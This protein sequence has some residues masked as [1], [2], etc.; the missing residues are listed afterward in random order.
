MSTPK[1]PPGYLN[2]LYFAGASSYTG[3]DYERWPAPLPLTKLLSDLEARYPGMQAK[4]LATC[5]MTVNLDYVDV[6]DAGETDSLV[7]QEFDEVA[8]IPPVS[9]G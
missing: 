4:V 7:L 8:I 1:P 3:K 2:V 6:P 9:A 5:M